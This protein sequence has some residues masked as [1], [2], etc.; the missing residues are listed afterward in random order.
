MGQVLAI[1]A[2]VKVV[3]ELLPMI[4]D[5]I[6]LLIQTGQ[7][8]QK[9]LSAVSEKLNNVTNLNEKQREC[10]QNLAKLTATKFF[11]NVELD[12][13]RWESLGQAFGKAFNVDVSNFADQMVAAFTQQVVQP[14]T[15]DQVL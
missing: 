10:L 1:V 4:N 3:K 9:F 8:A 5:A 11:N 12:K 7:T 2:A 6:G 14:I 13:S 15:H